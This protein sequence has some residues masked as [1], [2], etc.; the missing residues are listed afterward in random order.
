MRLTWGENMAAFGGLYE[1]TNKGLRLTA[2]GRALSML[3]VLLLV[4][5]TL[6]FLNVPLASSAANTINVKHIGQAVP[7]DPR[8]PLWDQ[9]QEATIPL[10]SQQIYQPGGGTT[11]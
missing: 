8:S 2:K 6:G 7:L 3:A 4:G 1:K 5:G 9:A 10:S 11:R